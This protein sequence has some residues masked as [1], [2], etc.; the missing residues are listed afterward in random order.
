MSWQT[1]LN[2]NPLPWLLDANGPGIR[3]LALRDLLNLPTAAGQPCPA[4]GTV[5]EKIQYLCGACYFCPRCQM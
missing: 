1:Q 2:G 5:V 4:C 3:Y